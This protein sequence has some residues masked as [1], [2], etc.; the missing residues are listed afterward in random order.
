MACPYADAVL[1]RLPLEKLYD[2]ERLAVVLA[3]VV[4]RADV[5]MV[6]RRSGAFV[7]RGASTLVT[8]VEAVSA[9]LATPEI[10][11]RNEGSHTRA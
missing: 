4:D 7:R 8:L 3:N 9:T 5:G 1:Q 10:A 11:G 2:D 6:E